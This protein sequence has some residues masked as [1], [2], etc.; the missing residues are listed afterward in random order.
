MYVK[1]IIKDKKLLK[2]VTNLSQEEFFAVTFTFEVRRWYNDFLND[3]YSD[4]S[5]KGRGLYNNKCKVL[6]LIM[7]L[8][9]KMSTNVLSRL[10]GLNLSTAIRWVRDYLPYIENQET[11]KNKCL[12][13]C[14]E[15]QI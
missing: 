9:H 7:L 15:E 8:R 14:Q 12:Q 2:L 1:Q 13:N 11:I 6:F 3:K 5:I 10:F 4:F